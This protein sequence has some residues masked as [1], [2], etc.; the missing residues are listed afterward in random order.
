MPRLVRAAALVLLAAMGG[1]CSKKVW[2]TQIPPFYTPDL[3]TI[4]VVPF[5]NRSTRR[6]A[7]NVI[8]DK[9]AAALMANGS[10]KVFNRNDLSALM[11]Q[12]DLK[13]ALSGD[14]SAAADKF[15]Q[16]T[17]VQA[18]LIGTVTTFSATSRTQRRKDPQY[19][20]D[21][22][23]RQRL[24]GYRTYDYTR[25]EANVSVTAVLIRVSDG[26]TIHS[27]PRPASRQIYSEGESPAMDPYACAAVAADWVV[28]QLV[29]EF[30]PVR[31]QISLNPGKALRTATGAEP[32]D[33]KWTYSDKF[34]VTDEK[35]HVVVALPASCDR[36]RFRITI[37]RKG[38]RVDLAFMD[39]VWTRQYAGYGYLFNPR[40]IGEKG[41]G[42]GEYEVKFYSGPEPVLR[43]T[44]KIE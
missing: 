29:A 11:D 38:E 26:T 14:T 34:S 13:I 7:G 31:R 5:R 30:A 17:N 20:Y 40:E 44:F 28:Y 1:G 15:K 24:A 33:N 12:Q 35:M 27:T 9:L 43:R 41:G 23:G 2:I 3:K 18:I 21:K 32:Y 42:P 39:I 10:Y 25:N 19:V 22:R 6:D 36:N 8:A 37:V 16:H 4:A